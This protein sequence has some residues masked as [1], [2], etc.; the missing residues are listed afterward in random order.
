MASIGSYGEEEV[1]QDVTIRPKSTRDGACAA[2][3]T[4]TTSSSSSS[5][6]SD[7]S[8]GVYVGDEIWNSIASNRS[9]VFLHVAVISESLFAAKKGSVPNVILTQGLLES[10]DALYGVVPMIRYDRIPA[11]FRQRY[12]LSD[13]LPEGWITPDPLDGKPKYI[14]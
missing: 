10:G 4:T 11:H 7:K 12:L 2:A 3:T 5:S 9:S 13:I 8:H 1:V 14:K 6:S